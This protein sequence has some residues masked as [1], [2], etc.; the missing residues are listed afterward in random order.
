MLLSHGMLTG[1]P[2]WDTTLDSYLD[3][4][5][6][7]TMWSDIF[8]GEGRGVVDSGPFSMFPVMEKCILDTDLGFI[9][10]DTVERMFANSTFSKDALHSDEAL[11]FFFSRTRYVHVYDRSKTTRKE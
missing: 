7:S 4:P 6:D 10:S 1:L 3:D 5:Y 8:M 11:E 9:G 2:Y